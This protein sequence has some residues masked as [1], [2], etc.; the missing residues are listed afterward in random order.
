MICIILTNDIHGQNMSDSIEIVQKQGV[1]FLQNGIKLTPRDLFDVTFLNRESREEM[2]I[3][4]RKDAIA[5]VLGFV[6]GCLVGWPV[7]TE[8]GGGEP[9]WSLA[10]VGAGLAA[11]GI[12]FALAYTKHAKKAVESFNK[13]PRKI[14]YH[15]AEVLPIDWTLF[16]RVLV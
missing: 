8:L 13:N 1:T 12:P 6:G 7:G 16:R 15:D 5:T 2:R 4:R 14:G 10:A 3:A 11:T 9:N